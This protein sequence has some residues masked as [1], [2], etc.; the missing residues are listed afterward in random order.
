M[1]GCIMVNALS[2]TESNPGAVDVA[3]KSHGKPVTLNRG[4]RLERAIETSLALA[5]LIPPF[6]FGGREAYGQLVLAVLVLV[7]SSLWMIRRIALGPSSIPVRR[8]EVLLV[9]GVFVLCMLSLLPLPSH[10]VRILSPGIARVLPG[11]TDG[12]LPALGAAGWQH[13]SVAPGLSLEGACLFAL[14]PLLFWITLDT[15]RTGESTYRLLHI[16]FITGTLVAAVGILHYLFWNGKFYGMWELCWVEPDRHVRAPLTNRN[17]FAGFLALTIGPG[18][19]VLMGLL[20]R[21]KNTS[22]FAC[23]RGASPRRPHELTIL[24]STLGLILVLAGIL[25]SQSRGGTIVGTL[26]LAAA[27]L[28]LLRMDSSKPSGLLV[29]TLLVLG[30]LGMVITFAREDPFQRSAAMLEGEA[31]LD[32]LSNQRLRLWKA[33][34]HALLDFPLL[35]SGAGTHRYVYPLYLEKAHHV[36]FTHAENGYVQVLLD[37]GLAGG[38]LLGLAVYCFSTW[39]WRS[40]QIESQGRMRPPVALAVGVSLLAALVHGVVDFVWY[41]PAYAGALAVLAGIACS[42]RR[43]WPS[44]PARQKRQSVPPST[45]WWR[46]WA[47]G[48]GLAVAWLS[49]IVIL[50]RHFLNQARAEFAWNAYFR[51]LPRDDEKVP[52]PAHP[53]TLQQQA[54]LLGE[55]CHYGGA[56]PDHY[57]RLGLVNLEIFL[58]K[59]RRARNT[60]SLAETR[61][62]LQEEKFTDAAKRF[63]SRGFLPR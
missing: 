47:W 19:I 34:L 10:L 1:N 46:K 2:Q 11:W 23:I 37:C 58:A 27:T 52:T 57:Y 45:P 4:S 9:L 25:L 33:D 54:D 63:G 20:R 13:F 6:V 16:F 14:Y 35:G 39:S 15:V 29:T 44:F 17:H 48:C 50:G 8:P 59:Q 51:L 30:G 43:S 12:T 40:I 21:W 36:T 41:V 7:A 3:E 24:L 32:E 22:P 26:A 55:T 31:S 42:L 56:D 18:M 28:G 49:L 53:D 5:I 61:A 38:V 60:F 62:L